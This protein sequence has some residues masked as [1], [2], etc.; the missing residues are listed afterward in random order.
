MVIA[1]CKSGGNVAV[2]FRDHL[3][4]K[5]L[6]L[7]VIDGD[8][9][10]LRFEDGKGKIVGLLEKGLAKKDKTGFVVEPE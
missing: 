10:D 7:E 2:V 1:L 6:G 8:D 9:S 4:D 3:P 5:W